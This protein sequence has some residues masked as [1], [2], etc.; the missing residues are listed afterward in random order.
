MPWK[1]QCTSRI[2]VPKLREIEKTSR[3]SV[4]LHQRKPLD[5]VSGARYVTGIVMIRPAKLAKQITLNFEC[6][7]LRDV[8]AAEAAL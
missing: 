4:M 1:G 6:A 8:M 3:G 5:D 7:I 2:N